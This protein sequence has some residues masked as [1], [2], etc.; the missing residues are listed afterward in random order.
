MQPSS[1][2]HVP[3]TLKRALTPRTILALSAICA[4]N[5][6]PAA[7]PAG[8]LLSSQCFQCHGTNGQ[9]V[10]G[11]EGIGGE[12]ANEMHKELLEMSLRKPEGIM[13]LQIRAYT[14]A[15]LRLIANYLST[16][17]KTRESDDD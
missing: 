4:C 7:P 16:L 3:S 11:F 13:D 8:Q 2:P 17:P 6:L 10:S 15:Q 5:A 1:K 9:P 12:N 14:P